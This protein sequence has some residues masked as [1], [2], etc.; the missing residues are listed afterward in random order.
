MQLIGV[1]LRECNEKIRKNLK[2]N[3]WYPFGS[4]E[5]CDVV[6][7]EKGIANV[8]RL[9]ELKDFLKQ[10]Q[11]FNS[12][13]YSLDT[14]ESVCNSNIPININCIV[15]KNGS[16]KSSLLSIVFRIINNFSCRIKKHL[17]DHN[18]DYNPVWAT[19]F[20]ADLYYELNKKVYCISVKNNEHPD[21]SI[22]GIPEDV[23]SRVFL[24]SET[25]DVFCDTENALENS[26]LKKISE[27]FFYTVGTNYSLYSN[28]VVT[29]EWDFKE[30]KWLGNI[31]HKNDGYF[32]PVVLV[33]YK[34]EWT[35]IDTKKELDL[36]KERISTLSLLVYAQTGSDFIENL[37][38]DRIC[39][40][41]IEK[42]IYK[43][44]IRKKLIKIISN[45]DYSFVSFEDFGELYNLTSLFY[46]IK[47]IWRKYLF[48]REKEA[49][50]L[51]FFNSNQKVSLSSSLYQNIK[52]NTLEYL[53]YKIIKMILYYDCYKNRF[54]KKYNNILNEFKSEHNKVLKVVKEIIEEIIS[55]KIKTNFTNLKIKQCLAFFN[56]IV[57]FVENKSLLELLGKDATNN[58]INE[59]NSHDFVSV[60]KQK[61]DYPGDEKLSYDY[62]FENLPPAYFKKQFYFMKKAAD[63]GNEKS[64]ITISSLS[65]GESQLL[66]SMSYAVYHIKNA[67][68][69]EI[70]YRNINLI[71]DEAELYYHPEYQ[72]TFI[73]DLLGIIKR[74]NLTGIKGINITLVTHSPFILSDIP[75][76]N[77]LC[78][79]E[80]Q[81]DKNS[82]QKTLGANFYD[83]LK[84][85]FF[86]DSS[87]GAVTE[88]IV[89]EILI[90][91]NKIQCKDEKL[92]TYEEK[93][94]I[95]NKYKKSIDMSPNFY[96]NFI[97]NLG[98]E[99]LNSTLKNMIGVIRN[100]TFKD[101][102]KKELEDKI[103]KLGEENNA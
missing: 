21:I 32:T 30:E 87:I 39:Y 23:D 51:S 45:N 78:L 41:M 40:E 34:S 28:S 15:G 47:K 22:A 54:S 43:N 79:K 71:F 16:G 44:L 12:I 10:N 46:H 20:D 53:S 63:D 93:N 68:S 98:D 62:I 61:N 103:K 84:N 90:D 42:S 64:N 80:G 18:Q 75:S 11:E 6:V 17:K 101:R 4:F 27:H 55:D 60:L 8:E 66:N 89:N 83:L 77:I 9:K 26:L 85:Q 19:G 1:Y 35:T 92:I 52:E 33:P 70:Q 50:Y 36:A 97:E 76:Q 91:F 100:E 86:M 102:R 5:K 88:K 81:Q 48:T 25:G 7:N 74:S 49:K 69:S 73:K 24:I 72:R 29:D 13:I 65:S 82:L 3:T 2:E 99:Y 94:K 37:I 57:F 56:N 67:L 14:T 59:K 31:Y 38:P 95:R 96:D 58:K